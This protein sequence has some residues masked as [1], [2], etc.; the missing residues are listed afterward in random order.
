[1]QA[2]RLSFYLTLALATLCL[3]VAESF[4]LSWILLLVAAACVAFWFAYR[5]EGHWVLSASAANGLGLFIGILSIGW[6]VSRVP[7]T[8]EEFLAQGVPWP[9]GMLPHLGPM[10]ILLTTAK[11]FRP[12]GETDFWVMQALGM[13][14]VML[15][16]VLAGEFHHAIFLFLYLVSLFWCLTLHDRCRAA[17]AGDGTAVADPGAPLFRPNPAGATGFGSAV[18]LTTLAC[19]LGIGVFYIAPRQPANQWIPYKLSGAG[20]LNTPLATSRGSSLDLNQVGKIELSEEVAFD[21]IAQDSQEQHP[22]LPSDMYWRTET[23]DYYRY[24]R[25]LAS[26]QPPEYSPLPNN[27]ERDFPV[28]V[29]LTNPNRGSQSPYE[30]PK[31]LPA[32]KVYL[33]FRLRPSM[34]EI[35]HAEHLD[36]SE[37]AGIGMW[38]RIGSRS[39]AI[40]LMAYYEGYDVFFSEMPRPPRRGAIAYGQIWD[41]AQRSAPQPPVDRIHPYYR[42][43]YLLEAPPKALVPW[44][45]ELLPR[46]AG[47]TAAERTLDGNGRILP[48]NQE[49]VARALSR[50]LS[51]SGEYLYS[52][53]LRLKDPELDPI[54]DFLINV[55]EGHCERYASGLVL[56]LRAVGIPSRLV[57]GFHGY[58]KD[59]N[60]ELHVRYSHAHSWAE[61]L[62][63]DPKRPGSEVWIALDPTPSE[64]A[65]AV[66]L[67]AWIDWCNERFSVARRGFRSNILEFGIDEQADWFRSLAARLTEPVTAATLAGLLA[68]AVIG[69]I[70]WRRRAGAGPARADVRVDWMRSF[71]RLAERHG[72]PPRA[73]ET[74]SE[75]IAALRAEWSLSPEMAALLGR[76][77]DS[78]DQIRFGRDPL[79]PAREAEL[80]DGV[81]RLRTALEAQG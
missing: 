22:D 43:E 12:K 79:A 51:E 69:G 54:A 38:P 46:L 5:H 6:I 56:M 78:Y 59:E 28:R 19:L 68:I 26:S 80:A 50:Y 8:E 49:R 81:K 37:Q 65:K 45:R 52:L 32:D 27:W 42:S 58:D 61:A 13:M 16:S 55:K 67:Q 47:I 71:L 40:S 15:A 14:M 34:G 11:V 57:K 66:G 1:M 9:A 36:K 18:L 70:L 7:R 24:G 20:A 23:L 60:G 3:G 4:F 25:W 17:A 31:D 30:L 10:L 73:Q 35:V 72:R 29:T 41:P 48:A 21:V 64:S 53:D 75:Y 74:W 76:F 63:P 39:S 62:V 2:F 33:T 44:T 77:V